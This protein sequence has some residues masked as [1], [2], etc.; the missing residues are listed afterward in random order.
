MNTFDE[1]THTY[2]IDGVAVP[3][4]TDVCSILTASKYAANAG[5]I[6]AARA[7]GTAVHELCE[8]YDYGVLDEVP[9]ELAGYV[10]AWAAFCRDY[11]PKWLYIEHQMWSRKYEMAGTCDRVGI[12]GNQTCVVDIKSTSS[13]D[14]SSKASLI[15]QLFGYLLLLHEN[16]IEASI[17]DSMGVQLKKDGT[18]TTH[19]IK[20][21]EGRYGINCPSLLYHCLE[22]YFA[23][24]GRPEWNKTN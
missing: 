18:Y 24:N 21:V 22:I 9:Q 2:T 3:S 12:I 17:N 7:R 8:A 20:S 4:V 16:G 6:E 14:R 1:A 19:S 11:R 10:K 5:A 23:K 15:A 13:M